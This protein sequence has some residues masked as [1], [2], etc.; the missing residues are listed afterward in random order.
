MGFPFPHFS[1]SGGEGGPRDPISSD[2]FVDVVGSAVMT[3]VLILDDTGKLEE[4]NA[5]VGYHHDTGVD[6]GDE[7]KSEAAQLDELPE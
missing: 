3:K 6:F 2:M 7:V 5:S 1:I 4:M